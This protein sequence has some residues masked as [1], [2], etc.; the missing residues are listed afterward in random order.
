MTP[1]MSA[2]DWT[3]AASNA[4][5]ALEA[6]NCFLDYVRA[7]AVE[8]SDL[9]A[10]RMVYAELV[11]N[12][13]RHAPGPIWVGLDWTRERQARLCVRD[14]GRGFA[15]TFALPDDEFS[16]SGR[17]LAIVAAIADTVTV[18]R[19]EAGTIVCATLPV[20]LAA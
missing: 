7:W 9:D 11:G 6:R 16:E 13:V 18:K 15:P 3:F 14:S 20:R 12:V 2:A 10:A 19:D 17:G 5:R 4:D 8:T 1:E